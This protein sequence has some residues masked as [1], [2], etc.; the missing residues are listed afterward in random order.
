[1][2]HPRIALMTLRYP[3]GKDRIYLNGSVCS[4]G[5]R[6]LAMGHE[7]QWID[8][9]IDR[10]GDQRCRDILEH[11]EIIGISLVGAPDIPGTLALLSELCER[12]PGAL[13]LL[14][15]QVIE[16]LTR[17][18]FQRVFGKYGRRLIQV[19][20]DR[21]L[22]QALNCAATDI[23]DPAS[24]SFT[25]LWQNMGEARL[26]TYMRR[27]M[28]L[29]V[30]QGCHFR[31]KF[32]AASKAKAETFRN[33]EKF[34]VDLRYMATLARQHQI[35]SLEFYAS[36]LDFFQ[37]PE[38]VRDYLEAIARVRAETRVDIRVRCLSCITSF[39]KAADRLPDFGGLLQRAGLWCVGFGSDGVDEEVWAAQQ[40]QHNSLLD[41]LQCFELCKQ[42]GLRAEMLMVFGFPED[43][44]ATLTKAVLTSL[45]AVANWPN[46]FIHPYL[47]KQAVPGNEGWNTE[48]KMVDVIVGDPEKF[49]DLDFSALGSRLTHPRIQ[50]RL[51][52]NA[53]YLFLTLALAPFGKC[54]STP[55]LP[56]S[57]GGFLSWI[58]RTI[59]QQL[60]CDR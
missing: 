60:P 47:A 29:V 17:E 44:P 31:C 26:L 53:A 52:C 24:V 22:A 30:S 10:L 19:S 35:Q 40:K 45:F 41:L 50:H 54:A 18:Q 37:N 16:R 58:A 2:K 42:L 32:C 3:Y 28:T 39:L 55:L 15:G 33:L 4:V 7:V 57:G 13:I 48:R 38:R 21:S 9:N 6:L 14:G 43:M 49:F 25:P 51:A 20:D 56:Q 36:S 34:E 1:M 59:N 8:L 12:A 46:L 27:E 11:A 23:P 5:A